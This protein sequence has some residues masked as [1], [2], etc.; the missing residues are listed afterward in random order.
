MTSFKNSDLGAKAAA[1]TSWPKHLRTPTEL[2]RA[3]R[4]RTRL[5][6][7]RSPLCSKLVLQFVGSWAYLLA[8]VLNK[9][10]VYNH[11]VF[12][13]ELRKLEEYH[14]AKHLDGAAP[15][16]RTIVQQDETK[17]YPTAV[18]NKYPTPK[19]LITLSNHISC[20]DDPVLWAVLLPFNYYFTKT[21]T[22]RWS[23]AA[24]DICFSKPWHSAFFSLGKT[25]P[26]IRGVGLNQPAMEFALAL[27]R[28]HQWLHLFPE[29]R[30]MR[31]E[32][33]EVISNLDRGYIF[34]WGISK[35]ILDYFKEAASEAR[36][37]SEIRILPFYHLGMDKVQPIGWPY[38]PRINKHITVYVRPSV[39]EMNSNLL[40]NILKTRTLSMTTAKSRSNDE[41]TRIKLTN[42]LEEELEKLIEPAR[43]AHEARN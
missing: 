34:K 6:V 18:D 27:L 20:I 29:G 43:I 32:K 10:R 17:S 14:D 24:V 13:R 1:L 38:I 19:P 30:V 3:L 8:H 40:A 22:V 5:K 12:N 9:S 31:N 4:D 35:L 11:E 36:H 33:Q 26:I 37:D 15:R 23:A 16:T 25:F 21:D 41:I 28:H 7:I 42:Y 39:I 2:I